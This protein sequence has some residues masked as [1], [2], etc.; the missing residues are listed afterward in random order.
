MAKEKTVRPR[1]ATEVVK[2]LAQV[3]E[4][5]IFELKKEEQAVIKIAVCSLLLSIC[6]FA[7]HVVVW[8]EVESIKLS[9]YSDENNSDAG[10]IFVLVRL[11]GILMES[12]RAD[13]GRNGG[14]GSLCTE[15]IELINAEL[16]IL[17]PSAE[18]GDAVFNA[19]A[20]AAAGVAAGNWRFKDEGDGGD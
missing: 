14:T 18:G 19:I 12:L 4:M 10:Y 17:Y 8:E 3:T 9:F 1:H 6:E 16:K 7:H 15:I 2:I 5:D 11:D 20:K 13:G